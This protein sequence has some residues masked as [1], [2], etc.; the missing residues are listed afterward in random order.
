MGDVRERKQIQRLGEEVEKRHWGN[1][2]LLGKEDS[3]RRGKK[4]RG[5]PAAGLKD[6]KTHKGQVRWENWTWMERWGI[7]AKRRDL[8]FYFLSLADDMAL[9][10]FLLQRKASQQLKIFYS[11]NFPGVLQLVE[12]GNSISYKFKM[13]FGNVLGFPGKC[14]HFSWPAFF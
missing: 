7:K 4:D 13:P 8:G 9:E 2:N 11:P 3:W 10:L 5:H 14:R 12:K 6:M 1:K